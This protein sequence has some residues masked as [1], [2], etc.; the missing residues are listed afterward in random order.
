M[1]TFMDTIKKLLS[2]AKDLDKREVV[3]LLAYVLKKSETHVISHDDEV[4]SDAGVK[5]FLSLVKRRQKNE[6]IAYLVG[7]QPFYG[8]D[9]IVNRTTLIPRPETEVLVEKIITDMNREVKR[10]KKLIAV[11]IG[12]GSGCIACA[13]KKNQPKA[14]V[15]A[16]DNSPTTLSVVKYNA[17]KLST[18]LEVIPGNLFGKK[19]SSALVRKISAKE[20]VALFV[21]ANLPYLPYSDMET[22]QKNVVKYEPKNALFADDDGME[23]IKKCIQQLEKFLTPYS[24]SRLS[25]H[26]YF[27]IDPR[28]VDCL[29]KFVKGTFK[30]TKVKFEKDLCGRMRFMTVTRHV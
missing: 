14:E 12:T 21:V 25:W 9:F 1:N 15:I 16:S 4:V 30:N 19:M 24:A 5:K 22:M 27:E 2:D 10:K 3:L 6:P 7:Y 28:Q 26:L 18:A 29:K 23:L 13:I 20:S 11:D 8:L 17:N